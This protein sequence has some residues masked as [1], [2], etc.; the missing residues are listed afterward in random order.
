MVPG[1]ELSL[2]REPA[3]PQDPNAVAVF[4]QRGERLGYLGRG[5]ARLLAPRMD[6]GAVAICRALRFRGGQDG[7][8]LGLDVEV[9]L[10][11]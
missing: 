9:Q 10:Q 8:N 5:L 4:T 1:Q 11:E 7:K 3:N 2:V 6:G